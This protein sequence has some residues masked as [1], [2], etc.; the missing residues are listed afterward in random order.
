MGIEKR[1]CLAPTR[2]WT[3][4]HPAQSMPL[5]LLCY[6]SPNSSILLLR[7]HLTIHIFSLYFGPYCCVL[8]YVFFI[9]LHKRTFFKDLES[10]WLSAGD[11]TTFCH[12]VFTRYVNNYDIFTYMARPINSRIIF[13]E[14]NPG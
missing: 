1:K 12:T 10:T 3:L 4:D 8:T 6:F 5:Y 9:S 13:Q 2:V 11:N 14:S 7:I